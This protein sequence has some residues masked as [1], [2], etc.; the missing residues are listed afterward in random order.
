MRKKKTEIVRGAG[1]LEALSRALCVALICAG[2]CSSC[3]VKSVYLGS[4]VKGVAGSSG[5]AGKSGGSVH[6]AGIG[7]D[8]GPAC[9]T[10]FGDCDKDPANGCEVDLANDR[11]H[12]GSCTA[13]CA[14]PDC[15]CMN[16][17][18]GTHCGDERADCNGNPADGCEVDIST[19]PKH[20]GACGKVCVFGLEAFG[21]TCNEGR[22]QLICETL[23]GD[24]DGNAATGCET[25][26]ID[27]DNCGACGMACNCVGG[28]CQ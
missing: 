10:G 2:L 4:N 7:H 27:N 21:A 3:D 11:N 26:L 17:Q 28:R 8:G 15:T 22:C 13:G 5:A 18:L 24:C 6:D 20:C 16:G 19:D 9:P 12:C 23:H 25:L 14:A 1:T